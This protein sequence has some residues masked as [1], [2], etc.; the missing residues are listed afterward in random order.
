MFHCQYRLQRSQ[1]SSYLYSYL[2]PLPLPLLLPLSLIQHLNPLPLDPPPL[3]RLNN[4]IPLR[5][6]HHNLH[7]RIPRTASNEL[8]YAR[9][10]RA[11]LL[12]LLRQRLR[13]DMKHFHARKLCDCF[14]ARAGF[15]CNVD[16][17][18]WA[19]FRFD[20]VSCLVVA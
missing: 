6:L 9:R 13:I 14:I 11:R 8:T 3:Q 1:L 10:A 16:F 19:R 18:R 7:H 12:Q 5:A 17:G 2:T 20:F 4:R 15:Q